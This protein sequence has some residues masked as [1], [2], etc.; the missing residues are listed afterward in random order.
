VKFGLMYDFR[1]PP[2][3]EVPSSQLYAETLEQ[4]KA[5]EALGFD[6]VWVTEHHFTDDGYLPSVLTA[7]AAIAAVTQ[8]VQIG[9][10]VLLLPLLHP[11]HVAEDGAIVD[12]ISS[13][14]F[15]FGPGLGYKLDEFDAFGVNRRHRPS[16][17]DESLEII[18]RAWT[19]DRFSFE[20]RHFQVKDLSVTPR[21][22]QKPRPPIWLAGR[23]EAP[24]R[25]AARLGDGVIAV[26]SNDLIR[27]YREFV[28]EEGKDPNAATVAVLRSVI[29]SDDPEKTWDELKDHVRWRSGR[30]GQWYGEAGD[31]PQDVERLERLRS[32]E[33]ELM[34]GMAAL[35]KDPDTIAREMAELEQLGVDHVIFFATFP[36][37]PL[38][39]TMQTWEAFAAKVMPRLRTRTVPAWPR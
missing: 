1:N 30:Y 32:G 18:S 19:E 3:W 4:I 27:R 7:A 12:I 9:T 14:R 34:G 28:A 20:G 36:G 35:I 29:I 31:L 21:P 2:P 39:R 24:L 10:S 23:A 8:R 15:I 26:A 25:R 6:S 16:L 17:M 38:S 11:L 5:V 22:V 37:Y 13:G 33:G